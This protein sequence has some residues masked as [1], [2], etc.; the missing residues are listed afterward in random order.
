[1]SDEFEKPEGEMSK[2]SHLPLAIIYAALTLV[3]PP[4]V[5]LNMEMSALN[6]WI[7]I[8]MAVGPIVAGTWVLVTARKYK[9]ATGESSTN[10]GRV[11]VT[12]LIIAL[13]TWL[14]ADALLKLS[15]SRLTSN[16]SLTIAAIGFA[17]VIFYILFLDH[18]MAKRMKFSIPSFILLIVSFVLSM[19]VPYFLG[20][21]KIFQD[22]N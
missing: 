10:A 4:Y 12:S 19:G 22:Y 11:I 1:M 16:W 14:V 3:V 15:E 20:C 21:Y 9:S 18:Q 5:L 13:F 6:K 8:V 7:P 2:P 17:A